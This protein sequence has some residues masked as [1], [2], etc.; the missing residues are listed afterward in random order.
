MAE[1]H[2]HAGEVS[3]GQ[4]KSEDARRHYERALELRPDYT[5]A[6]LALKKLEP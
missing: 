1:A 5:D 4:G 2:Y 6:I 3:A